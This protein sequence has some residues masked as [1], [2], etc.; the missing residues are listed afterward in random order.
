[1][2][3]VNKL[4]PSASSKPVSVWECLNCPCCHVQAAQN[5]FSNVSPNYSMV[6][7]SKVWVLTIWNQFFPFS[8]F[9]VQWSFQPDHR[10]DLDHNMAY[11]PAYCG[12]ADYYQTVSGPQVS[13]GFCGWSEGEG[14]KA[15]MMSHWGNLKQ[16][17]QGWICLFD[18]RYLWLILNSLSA[19]KCPLP[20]VHSLYSYYQLDDLIKSLDPPG[21]WWSNSITWQKYKLWC[22]FYSW[23]VLLTPF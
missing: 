10:P 5:N 21:R 22:H 16:G 17:S 2:N 3:L 8:S 23:T 18:S 7:F 20:F 14:L 6:Q 15:S 12:L 4:H 1:M 9:S 11:G 19:V 13:P